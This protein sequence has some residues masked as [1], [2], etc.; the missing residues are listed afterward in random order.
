M[1]AIVE[2]GG[3]QVRVAPNTTV[4][5]DRLPQAVGDGVEF[6]QVL[7]VH[8]GAQL[9]VGTPYVA[10]A[11]VL[12]RVVAQGKDRKLRILTYRPKKRT[13]RRLGHRQHHT[14]VQILSIE[15]EGLPAAAAPAEPAEEPEAEEPKVKKRA[16]PARASTRKK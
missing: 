2:A 4:K 3:R 8:D 13:R 14:M 16:T 11:K 10:G 9:T 5:L 15:G 6:S 12:G 7:A 1:Y